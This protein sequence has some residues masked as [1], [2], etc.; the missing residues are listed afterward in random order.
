MQG[1][2]GGALQGEE[3]LIFWWR[4]AE[5]MFKNKITDSGGMLHSPVR[6][7]RR[8]R[9]SSTVEHRLVKKPK[10]T[11]MWDPMV[12]DWR[13]VATQY[14]KEKCYCLCAKQTIMCGICFGNHTVEINNTS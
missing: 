2:E 6:S 1:P 4:L 8:C 5:Q 13:R 12:N 10:L 11:G 3:G 7:S 9:R 14:L